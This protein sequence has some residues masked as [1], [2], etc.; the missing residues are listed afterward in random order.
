MYATEIFNFYKVRILEMLP[1]TAV[2]LLKRTRF[3]HLATSYQD[4]PHVTLMN[5]TYYQEGDKEFIIITTQKDST[6]YENI[7][8]N[9]KVSM[10]VHDWTSSK[11][12]EDT[13]AEPKR[14]NSLFEL[15]TNLNK[16]EMSSISIMING[17]AQII[18]KQ[19]AKY[20]FYKSLHLNNDTIEQHQIDSYVK[21]DSNELILIQVTGCKISDTDNNVEQY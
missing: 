4:C 15:I 16:T 10:L 13:S 5:Y 18:D 14:R 17:S 2:K 20:N 6:K 1:E 7:S 19:D 12:E 8:H 11:S 9:N 21:D 3:L